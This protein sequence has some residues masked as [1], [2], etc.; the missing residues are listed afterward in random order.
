MIS[1]ASGPAQRTEGPPGSRSRGPNPG[2]K[3]G[4]AGSRTATPRRRRFPSASATRPPWNQDRQAGSERSGGSGSSVKSAIRTSLL[5]RLGTGSRRRSSVSPQTLQSALPDLR[6]QE[7]GEDTVRDDRLA[8]RVAVAGDL[9]D[10]GRRRRL[11]RG[12][13]AHLGPRLPA[14]ERRPRE[15]R[16]QAELRT[17]EEGPRPG[18]RRE[19]EDEDERHRVARHRPAVEKPEGEKGRDEDEEEIGCGPRGAAGRRRRV[20]RRRGR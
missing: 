5:L 12:A 11:A 3:S 13:V 19:R 6:P 7:R 10:G 16:D 4:G 14:E 9:V 1:R 20:P 17:P 15:H 8:P 2:P 18:R